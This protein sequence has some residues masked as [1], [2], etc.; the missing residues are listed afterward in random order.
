MKSNYLLFL[1]VLTLCSCSNNETL[2]LEE[3]QFTLTGK[4]VAPNGLDPISNAKARVYLNTE[5]KAEALTDSQGNY[6]LAVP[7]GD[8]TLVLNKG[9]F[10]TEK[11]ITITSDATLETFQVETFP[12]IGVVTGYYDNIESVLYDIGLVNPITQ[13]PLFDI[14]EGKDLSGRH[15]NTKHQQHT[16]H[17]AGLNRSQQNPLLDPNV[18]YHFGDLMA[19]PALM[20]TYDIIFLNC[21]LSEVLE[22]TSSVL[23]DYV[24]NGG[25]LYTTDWAAGYLD[26]ITNSGA[27]YLT[28]YTPEKSGIST[29]TTATILNDDLSAWLLL[30]F[31]ISINN[32]VEIH[33]FLNSWQVIDSHD[34]NTTISWLNGPVTYRDDMNVDISE[35]KDLA[36]TFLH[37][38]GAVFYSS[39]HTENNQV[40]DFSDV[41]RI[42]QFL[43]FEMSVVE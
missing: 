12:T 21:G 18:S 33:D 26:A 11:Q 9:K 16:A 31:N 43:V 27:N 41:D 30:N 15:A 24:S 36:F 28:P 42:M 10:K 6:T 38:N 17:G 14:I 34:A 19:D 39:F 40:D 2:V 20:A 35:N 37:G 8:F 7:Q 22:D 13:T 23:A 4:F 1:I 5:L 25:V 29:T 32:T 3:V